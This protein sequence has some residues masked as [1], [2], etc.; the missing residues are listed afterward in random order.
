MLKGLLD[1]HDDHG[2]RLLAVDREAPFQRGIDADARPPVHAEGLARAW[3]QK[4]QPDARILDEVLHAVDPIVAPAIRDQQGSAIILDLDEAGLVAFGRAVEPRLASGR[5]HEK[6]RGG[7]EGPTWRVD[8]VEFLL[9]HALRWPVINRRQLLD[10][11]NRVAFHRIHPRPPMKACPP[12]RIAESSAIA[13]S[14]S[15]IS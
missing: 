4:D 12:H 14:L 3:H 1:G 9:N 10:R 15:I 2:P 5:K 7:D 8:M 13:G 11:R 6:G